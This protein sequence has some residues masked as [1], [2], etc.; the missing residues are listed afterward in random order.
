M[1]VDF[2]IFQL[3]RRIS[4]IEVPLLSNDLSERTCL[5]ICPVQAELLC[6][7]GIRLRNTQLYPPQ[8][9]RLIIYEPNRLLAWLA[10]TP[11]KTL[12]ALE[13]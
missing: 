1:Q 2:V 5:A 6:S 12:P 8:V 10:G 3:Y 7:L 9:F 4:G 13:C 11:T